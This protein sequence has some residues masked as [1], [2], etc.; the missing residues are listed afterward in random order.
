MQHT[1]A[2][3][4]EPAG[5]HELPGLRLEAAHTQ[6]DWV[7]FDLELHAW[8]DGSAIRGYWAY[9]RDL[10]DPPTIEDFNLLLQRAVLEMARDPRARAVQLAWA[11]EARCRNHRL[12]WS[13]QAQTPPAATPWVHEVVARQLQANPTALALIQGRQR[14]SRG[15]LLAR[16]GALSHPLVHTGLQ[17][18]ERV[19]LLLERSPWFVAGL[20]GIVEAGGAYVPLDPAWPPERLGA[21]CAACGV[22]RIVC[23]TASA[24]QAHRV[25][26]RWAGSR[27]SGAFEAADTATPSVI[28]LQRLA[29]ETD[30]NRLSAATA[31]TPSGRDPKAGVATMSVARTR[32]VLHGHQ[33]LYVIATSGSTGA[34]KPVLVTH[35]ALANH[36]AWMRQAYP[37]GPQDRVLQ[38]TATTFDASVWEFWAPLMEGIPLIMAEPGLQADPQHPLDVMA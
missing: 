13:A 7:R 31:S 20:L 8:E 36:M 4:N 34:P 10:F 2:V 29:A 9:A 12:H 32:T 3:H 24:A 11:D 27:V 14:W 35:E 5:D 17:P 6:L 22:R 28:D 15:D 1:V 16:A 19:G 33:G 25:A 26:A 38:R 18:D 21:V 30:P 23:D 37:L